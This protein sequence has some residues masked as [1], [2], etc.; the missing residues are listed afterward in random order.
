MNSIIYLD[1][2]AVNEILITH[3]GGKL[4]ETIERVNSNVNIGGEVGG[5]VTD[6][7]GLFAKLKGAITANWERGKEEE[8]VYDL[9][10]E[11]AKFALLL[12]VLEASGATQIDEGFS[13]RDR[14]KL[15]TNSPVMISAPLIHT[16]VDEIKSGFD[17]EQTV[18][19]ISEAL[20]HFDK[21]GI[22][23]S[24]NS[25]KLEEMQN[26]F[27]S[28]GHASK[29]AKMF[30]G[31]LMEHD[32]LYR[33]N[34]SS[35]VDFVMELPEQ[36]FRTR[37]LDFP[38]STKPYA[39]LAQIS[40]KIERGDDVQLI[41]F[42]DLAEKNTTNPRER[43]TEELKI[44]RNVANMAND[45]LDGREISSSEFELSYPDVQIQPLAIY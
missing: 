7:S 16:P 40:T 42:A 25:E 6:P 20:G 39:V 31:S 38:S 35:D 37:P 41:P 1:E 22:L 17:I 29:G 30:F 36:N 43:K 34:T 13:A 14:N 24:E 19:G 10:D 3:H 11:M 32:D 5:E 2:T 15:T 27:E 12:E 45:I 8:F 33:T 44:R 28:L 4:E 18:G 9:K 23:D 21:S 26:E